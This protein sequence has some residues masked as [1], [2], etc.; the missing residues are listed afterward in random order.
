MYSH[1]FRSFLTTLDHFVGHEVYEM[2][3]TLS[4]LQLARRG[5]SIDMKLVWF[6]KDSFFYQLVNRLTSE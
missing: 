5:E 4:Y 6:R 1:L 2:C 3:L